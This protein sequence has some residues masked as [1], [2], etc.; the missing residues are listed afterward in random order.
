MTCVSPEEL[1]VACHS[2]GI[3]SLKSKTWDPKSNVA[4][5]K[6]TVVVMGQP[7]KTGP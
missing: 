7:L 3:Q 1:R 4:G 2:S 5:C 6:G